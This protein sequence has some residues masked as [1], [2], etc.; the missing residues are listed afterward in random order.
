MWPIEFIKKLVQRL[1]RGGPSLS[2]KNN[3][4]DRRIV[5]PARDYPKTPENSTI[6]PDAHRVPQAR[7]TAVPPTCRNEF[8]T[9]PHVRRTKLLVGLPPSSSIPSARIVREQVSHDMTA[10]KLIEQLAGKL[11]VNKDKW[12]LLV[13][14]DDNAPYQ[15]DKEK[16]IGKFLTSK[17][18]RLYFYPKAMVR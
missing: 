13:F 5:A 8:S 4:F 18:E 14:S 11:G 10:E 1:L 2:E 7:C 3:W 15:L 16:S 9:Q 17:T 6:S 12:V